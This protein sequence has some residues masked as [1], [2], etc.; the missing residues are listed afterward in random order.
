VTPLR[1]EI[2]RIIA[3][4]GPITVERYMSLCLAHPVY[5]YY[6]T[7]DPLGAAGDFTTAPEIS[8][9]FGELIGL[10]A[11]E[12]WRRMGEPTLLRLVEL[13]PG[14][15]T[16]M[17]DALRAA[18]LVPEFL[19][20]ARVHLVET[21]PVLK[22]RQRQRLT[23]VSPPLSWHGRLD[24]VPEGPA[25]V[26]ANEFFDAL[27][28]RQFVRTEAGFVER[29][30]GLDGDHL[31]FGLAPEPASGLP[32]RGRPGDVLEW[33]ATAIETVRSLAARLLGQGGA[34]LVIDYGAA[35]P[36]FGDT[37]QA[38]RRHAYADPLAEP[39]E[40]DLTTHVDFATMARTAAAA[41]VRTHGPVTQGAFL[42]GLGI[43]ARAAALAGSART[44]DPAAVRVALERLVGEGP[45]AMGTLFK[46]LALSHPALAALPGLPSEVPTD[47][48]APPRP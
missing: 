38:V 47:A 29:L 30:V 25:L 27:P 3:L 2:G 9:M 43:E 45:D 12:V 1:R 23:G 15:G 42:R 32:P 26:V 40:A 16:L 13:G 19:A 31:A 36:G 34:A 44:S 10:W 17:A 24:E 46:V 41:G 20:A 28:V 39:G 8:Q 7:R 6:M 22:E 48:A 21:S 14:R 18:R 33:P 11:A 4:E 5:G 35:G 37:L